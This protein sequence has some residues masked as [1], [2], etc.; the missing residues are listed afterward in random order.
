MASARPLD[1]RQLTPGL[2]AVFVIGVTMLA[3]VLLS[4]V[5][6]LRGRTQR[7]FV[8]TSDATGLANGTVVVLAG[9][10]V[11]RIATIGFAPPSADSTRPIVL[12]LDVRASV[13]PWLRRPTRALIT[14]GLNPSGETIVSLAPGPANQPPVAPGDTLVGEA[15]PRI[16]A[17]ATQL[18]ALSRNVAAVAG[19]ARVLAHRVRGAEGA[20]GAL[21]SPAGTAPIAASREAMR[22]LRAHLDTASGAL[23]LLAHDDAMARRARQVVAR[24]DSIQVLLASSR[25]TLGRLRRD[26]TLLGEI[27]TIHAQ[28]VSVLAAISDADGSAGRAMRDSTVAHQVRHVLTQIAE[29]LDDVKHHPLRYLIF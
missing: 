19:D 21:F 12:A 2:L 28:L 13:L 10:P 4:R 17:L 7:L 16:E 26:S 8:V 22:S 18:G 20:L 11:G 1:W 14:A 3:I 24:V 29:F 27:D 9:Q 5:D 15:A 6:A 23:R 25:G